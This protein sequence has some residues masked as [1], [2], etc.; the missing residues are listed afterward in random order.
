MEKSAED[1]ADD[2]SKYFM[3]ACCQM[4]SVNSLADKLRT[5]YDKF[6]EAMKD[7]EYA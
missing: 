7:D 1:F 5:W 6:G 4:P 2:I 3:Q